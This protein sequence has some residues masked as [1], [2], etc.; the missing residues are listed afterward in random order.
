MHMHT[1]MASLLVCDGP[2]LEWQSYIH[3]HRAYSMLWTPAVGEMLTL[4]RGQCL[5]LSCSSCDDKWCTGWAHPEI[6]LS[7]CF[8]FLGKGWSQCCLRSHRKPG[9]SWRTTWCR[10]TLHLQ[11]LW[12]PVVHRQIDGSVSRCFVTHLLFDRTLCL[13]T[14][15]LVCTS[16]SSFCRDES[17]LN[18]P[19][20]RTS[21]GRSSGCNCMY[22][23]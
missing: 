6:Y 15:L 20:S 18:A 3:S 11:I 14:C 7:S 23:I 1:G 19:R 8:L 12:P 5:R 4:G 10:S 21:H 13:L 22:T 16:F 17:F 2:S 9:K